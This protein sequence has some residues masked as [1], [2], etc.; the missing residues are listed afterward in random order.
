MS[1]ADTYPRAEVTT[2]P[3]KGRMRRWLD[4][5]QDTLTQPVETVT[6]SAS[7]GVTSGNVE[8]IDPPEDI[9]EYVDLYY[10]IGFIRKNINEFISDVIE[11]G[12]RVESDHDA[13]QDYFMGGDSAPDSAPENGFLSECFVFDEKRQPIRKGL[14]VT[15]RNKWV[16]GTDLV[17][18]LK[19][20]PEDPESLIT[21]FAHIRPETV[22]PR[23]YPNTN[24]LIGPEDTE[25]ADKTTKRGEAAAY[26]QFDQQSILGRRLNVFDDQ[27][28]IP[29]SQNDV[30][31]QTL[32][33]DIGGQNTEDGVFGRSI[34]ESVKDDAEEYRSISRD[35][36]EAIKR[37]AFGLYTV[38]FN[39][40]VIENAGG[41]NILVEWDS[42]D[43]QAMESEIE[44]AEPGTVL[45]TDAKIELNR[46][47]PDLPDL[48]GPMRRRARD[49]VDPLP[50]PFYKHSQAD[51]INQF[52]T[53]DQQEDYQRLIKHERNEQADQ[54]QQAFRLVAERHPELDPEG[55]DVVIAPEEEASPIRTLDNETIERIER[56][57]SAVNTLVEAS[58]TGILV[59]E[60]EIRDLV[61]QLPEER[62]NDAQGELDELQRMADDAE[63]V[64]DLVTRYNGQ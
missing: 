41:E 48:D 35:E 6:R 47:Q 4:T 27:T 38:Q 26:V 61:L 40:Y 8:A 55:L 29:L 53:E 22:R 15:I 16:R 20:D 46:F 33:Q 7:L 1:K 50:A 12:V 14:R 64:D 36:A 5:L 44:N 19:A 43:I 24:Q 3:P 18:Y 58:Q 32:D 62:E 2:A 52:V 30:L 23:T 11:P 51:E 34:I 49:I 60:P 28:S 9:D 31:K 39:D 63:S 25:N 13:T 45:T 42:D 37:I 59:D 54:W 57:A 10:S 17:E 56:Y 21:G